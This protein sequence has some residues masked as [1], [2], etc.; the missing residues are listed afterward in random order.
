MN[1]VKASVP[2]KSCLA[3]LLLSLWTTPSHAAACRNPIPSLGG[4]TAIYR[5]KPLD[6]AA[7]LRDALKSKKTYKAFQETFA[8]AHLEDHFQEV[9]DIIEHMQDTD[10][11][12]YGPRTPFVWMAYRAKSDKQVHLLRNSCWGGAKA[13]E[14]WEFTLKVGDK[15]RTYIIPINCLNL[16]LLPEVPHKPPTC[17]LTANVTC[18]ST[19]APSTITII[20]TANGETSIQDVVI[21]GTGP[22]GSQNPLPFKSTTNRYEWTLEASNSGT[23]FFTAVAKDSRGIESPACKAQVAVCEKKKT[24]EPIPCTLEVTGKWPAGADQGF[25]TIKFDKVDGTL[26]HLTGPGIDE[27]LAPDPS[28]TNTF[29]VSQEGDYKVA[30]TRPE[31]GDNCKSSSCT[32][33][34]NIVKPPPPPPPC[35]DSPWL[36]R[37][38]AGWVESQGSEQTGLVRLANGNVG[39]FKFGF[40][41]G[42]GFG[43]ELERLF[44]HEGQ[45]WKDA[46]WG[47]TFGL[48]RA[49][50]NT[51]WQVDITDRYWIR[52]KDR[53]PMLTLTTGF[54][55]HWRGP[56]WDFFAGPVV[57]YAQFEDGTYADTST[58]PGTFRANFDDNFTYG[59][60]VGFDGFLGKCWGIT[61]GVEY[62]K[63]STKAGFLDVDVDPLILKAG[64]VY[65]F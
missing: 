23:Y 26:L 9:M 55:Y 48:F 25:L 7:K 14:A 45:S 39:A 60:N 62:L 57:G 50:V 27:M 51:L 38:Y 32:S 42:L 49:N 44:A 56:K 54:N 36:L 21:G 13:F 40:N 59:A 37:T 20:A 15:M 12:S 16:A 58:K 22:T 24:C 29:P 53:V 46:R 2:W 64:F 4:S 18:S 61:G 3:L 1:R 52:D 31:K 10:K 35:C 43:L 47:W 11:K 41:E 28:G 17:S 6:S 63:V 30:L 5:G 33:T 19:E 65:H 8:E 34:V